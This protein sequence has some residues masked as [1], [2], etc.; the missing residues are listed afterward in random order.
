[1]TNKKEAVTL[2]QPLFEFEV[3]SLMFDVDGFKFK[4]IASNIIHQT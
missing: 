2:R 3:E 4:D 1:L